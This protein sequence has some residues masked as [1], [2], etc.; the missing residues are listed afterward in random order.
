MSPLDKDL[1]KQTERTVFL[2]AGYAKYR[3]PYVWLRS[4]HDKLIKQ[5]PNQAIE[6]DNPL[7]LRKT[8]EWKTKDVALWEILAEIL[9]MTVHPTNPFEVDFDYIDRLPLEESVLLT[10]SLM[11]FLESIWIQA[12]PDVNYI[13]Q[14]YQDI[15]KLQ[16]RHLEKV[17]D[18]SLKD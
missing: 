3:C 13:E 9:S 4:H 10:G 2:I 17:Y 14:V 6:D 16:S 11:A 1:S 18:Y 8:S 12:E 15:Q 5:Q 7:Q